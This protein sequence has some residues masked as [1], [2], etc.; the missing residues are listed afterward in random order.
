MEKGQPTTRY[1]WTGAL[2]AP[3]DFR[4][5]LIQGIAE[6]DGSVNVASQTVEF[7]IDPSRDFESV[8]LTFGVRSFRNREALSVSKTQVKGLGDI[9][10]FSPLL[11]TVRYVRS[12]KLVTAKHIGHGKRLPIEI[13]DFIIR[14]SEGS[15]V[16]KLSEMVLDRF[17]V[18]LSF[19]AV[20]R[21][22]KRPTR[23]V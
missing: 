4:R 1:G 11:K 7:W 19:E 22:A 6:S 3:E 15:S 23:R 18:S 9:P 21:W 2:A 20:Q 12:Q 14:R 10:A 13:R 16:P 5:G 17:G 8:L